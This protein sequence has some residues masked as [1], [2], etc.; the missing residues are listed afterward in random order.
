MNYQDS[1]LGCCF[2]SSSDFLKNPII[3]S[4]STDIDLKNL[5]DEYS[6]LF[7]NLKKKISFKTL[8]SLIT[9]KPIVQM[10][11]PSRTFTVRCDASGLG[12]VIKENVFFITINV[13][14]INNINLNFINL[15]EY[16]IKNKV[17]H[18]HINN[19]PSALD[20]RA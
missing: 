9:N 10:F 4:I 12:I 17:M 5:L 13:E 15:K 7:E 8:K 2:L 1:N 11:D 6:C 16:I 19:K 14:T 20:H 18:N 3:K